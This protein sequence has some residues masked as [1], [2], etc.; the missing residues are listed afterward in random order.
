MRKSIQ[1]LGSLGELIAAI[2]TVV[3][4][5]YLAMQIRQNTTS[6]RTAT[7]QNI[8]TTSIEL[9][10]TFSR[11]ESFAE[12]FQR[13]AS[14]PELLSPAELVRLHAHVSGVLHCYELV[15][16]Q[17]QHGAIEEDVWQGWRLN[18]VRF[19]RLAGYRKVWE[20]TRDEFP[21]RF[22]AEADK[23]LEESAPKT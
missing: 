18:M 21:D 5:V 19:L 12:L 2:A 4:L 10:N 15:F 16:H 20:H 8:V 22:R 11:D 17:Y 6:S 7:Y 3:T 14:N 9:G 13:G 1:D 23:A